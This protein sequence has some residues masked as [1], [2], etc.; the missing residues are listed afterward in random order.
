MSVQ[1]AVGVS[2]DDDGIA[3]TNLVKLEYG[4]S[5]VVEFKHQGSFLLGSL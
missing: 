3:F 2:G 4:A 1:I 5:V